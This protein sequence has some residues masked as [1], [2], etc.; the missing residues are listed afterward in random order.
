MNG[1]KQ[2]PHD[3]LTD[4]K[5]KNQNNKS[6]KIPADRNTVNQTLTYIDID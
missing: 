2:L 6:N 1:S 3:I 5:L 4:S